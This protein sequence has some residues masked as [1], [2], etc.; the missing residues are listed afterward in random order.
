MTTDKRGVLWFLILAFGIA[1]LFW[2]IPLRA[3]LALGDPMF[4]LFL[5]PGSFAP[6]IAAVVVRKWI[7]REGFE[8]AGF[9]L[10][11]KKRWR[12]YLTAWLLPFVVIGGIIL[13]NMVFNVTEPVVD[14][15]EAIRR[16]LPEGQEI[17]AN[18]P[19]MT[20]WLVVA[21]GLV[22][23]IMLSRYSGAKN[24]AGADICSCDCSATSR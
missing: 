18:A 1:W 6:A 2:E 12:I 3:G 14:A 4:Q 9:K 19:P 23:S 11:F 24:S 20:W 16:T 5:L 7:T 13:V 10:H 15:Q 21:Q 17:P 22:M 8:D